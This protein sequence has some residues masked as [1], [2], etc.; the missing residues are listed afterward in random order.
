MIVAC[1]D[2]FKVQQA[3]VSVRK[4]ST[5]I[6]RVRQKDVELDVHYVRCNWYQCI[7]RLDMLG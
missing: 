6:R 2:W 1:F 7:V 3:P 4:W 5:G